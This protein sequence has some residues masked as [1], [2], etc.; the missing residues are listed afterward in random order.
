MSDSSHAVINPQSTRVCVVGMGYIGLPSA[1]VLA[2]RGYQIHGVDVNPKAVET[3]NTGRA[4]IV[5]PDLDM[6]VKAAVQTG[7]L[8][9]HANPAPSDI[10]IVCVPTPFTGDHDPDLSYVFA[11]TK[12][13][14]PFIR[15]GNLVILES[16]SPPGTT[17]AMR[18]IVAKETGLTDQQVHFAHA[19][20]RVLPGRIIREVVENDRIVGGIG[21]AA[22]NHCAEF[23]RTFVTGQVLL[24]SAR[25]A[26]TTKLVENA[27]RDVNIAFAN[28]LS[29][30]C[31]ELDLDVWEVISLA[32]RHPRVKILNPG[33]GVGGHCIA[34]DPWFLVKVAPKATH[35]IH[36]ARKINDHKPHWVVER[37][38]KR[39]KRI[40][41]P[42]IACLGLAYKPDI[43]DLRES[44][45]VDVAKALLAANV[46]E[47][48]VVEPNIKSHPDFKLCT[49]EEALRDADI[50]VFLVAHQSFKRIPANLLADRI[51]IDTCGAT[52]R[53]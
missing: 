30:V 25:T 4:H 14:C 13:I 42:K 45:A 8:K 32:N 6:L 19:P 35:L 38:V 39:A 12:S 16:T 3:I 33:P 52:R 24:T 9:V 44:P 31:D 11:A 20:E 26:E 22:T 49:A 21:E 17:E 46:G 5:E 41:N 51:I 1:A 43:D 53:N 36:T 28:E 34:V 48:R 2:S 27:Y 15:E 10:F 29:L 7:R 18:D 23:Y 50:V 37:V 47:V 40:N